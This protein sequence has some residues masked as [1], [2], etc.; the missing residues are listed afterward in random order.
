MKMTIPLLF[1]IFFSMNTYAESTKKV[2]LECSEKFSRF[3]ITEENGQYEFERSVVLD[4]VS[5]N[6][7]VAGAISVDS[8][9]MIS[10][11]SVTKTADGLTFVLED[12][13]SLYFKIQKNTEENSVK[14]NIAS[15]AFN[16]GIQIGAILGTE[17]NPLEFYSIDACEAKK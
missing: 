9:G 2:L 5:G 1:S 17:V 16:L 13:K 8:H 10:A 11:K 6:Q 3:E 14:L 7:F 12:G 15:N 4:R